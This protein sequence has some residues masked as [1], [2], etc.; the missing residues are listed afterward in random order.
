MSNVPD[1]Y[2]QGFTT[3]ATVFLGFSLAFVRFWTMEAPGE[4][5]P[6]SV[7][8]AGILGIS[9]LLQL[10]SLFRS[11]DVRDHE[12]SHYR[13]TVRWFLAAVLVLIAGVAVSIASSNAV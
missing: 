4:W 3:A 7:V 6:H 9:I 11:L 13:V 10:I 12:E 2:R 8:A 5:S 1:G